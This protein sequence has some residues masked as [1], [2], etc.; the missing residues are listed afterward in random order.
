MAAASWYPDPQNPAQLRYFDGTQWT[1]H[2]NAAAPP[3]QPMATQHTTNVT[4]MHVGNAG[5]PKSVGLAIFLAFM[6]GPLGTFYG[7]VVGG[8]VLL[9]SSFLIGWLIIPLP[10]IWVGSIIWGAV[11]ASQHNSRFGGAAMSVT[12]QGPA[13]AAAAPVMPQ[14]IPAPPQALMPQ[15]EPTQ[16]YGQSA[17]YQ[18]A[19]AQGGSPWAPSDNDI[20]DAEVVAIEQAPDQAPPDAGW[21]SS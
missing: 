11:G 17:E 14:A 9:V 10:F 7:S 12:S 3:S 21:W 18:P 19:T 1:E 13:M 20:V 15:A 5:P 16:T 2:V 4:M 8:A 6:F